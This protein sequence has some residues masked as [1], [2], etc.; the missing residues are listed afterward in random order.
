MGF[1][2]LANI[3]K[4][5]MRLIR[6]FSLDGLLPIQNIPALVFIYPLY[7]LLKIEWF[8]QD[9]YQCSWLGLN[10]SHRFGN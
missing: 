8:E 6:Y 5:W 1:F 4:L 7:K 3:H 10:F 2:N 9:F